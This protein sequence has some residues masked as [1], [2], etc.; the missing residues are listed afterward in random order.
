MDS[1]QKLIQQFE[2]LLEG[3][4]DY[5]VARQKHHCSDGSILYWGR[6]QLERPPS[7]GFDREALLGVLINAEDKVR[8][9]IYQTSDSTP[10]PLSGW[11]TLYAFVFHPTEPRLITTGTGDWRS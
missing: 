7:R 9:L 10:A 8:I 1:D 6:D 3:N 4:P 5:E 2:M 11:G